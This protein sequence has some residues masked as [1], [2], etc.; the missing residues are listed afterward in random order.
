MTATPVSASAAVANGSRSTEVTIPFTPRISWRAR[1]EAGSFRLG[2][3]TG[4]FNLAQLGHG[5]FPLF[6][7]GVYVDI[8][9]TLRRA[10]GSVDGAILQNQKPEGVT[11]VG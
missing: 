4:L 8:V 9:R 3:R 6:A 7:C 1:I 11:T 10:E 5:E 2:Q